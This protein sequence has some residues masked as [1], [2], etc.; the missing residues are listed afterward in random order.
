MVKD[1]F[2]S[3]TKFLLDTVET[4]VIALAMFAVVYL[5]LVQPHQVRGES[6]FPS[7]EDKEY[8]L[9]EKVTYRFR[10]PRRGEVV[11]FKYPKA[12]EY[13]YIKRV[14]GLPGESVVI[15]NNKVKIFNTEH[16]EGFYLNEPYIAPGGTAAK[17]T[18]REGKIF[19]IPE[20]EYIVMGDNRPRSS[21][22]R[23]WGT[24]KREGFV[25]RAWIVYWP[26]QA[27]AF[28]KETGY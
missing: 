15:E 6:M 3:L 1:I 8:I 28:I 12:P 23:E 2:K 18:L 22:S 24:V 20:G 27:L 16:P 17:N 14:V 21:D 9:T 25:G 4:I 5:F 11:V 13:D 7:F 19:Q 26:P 10:E